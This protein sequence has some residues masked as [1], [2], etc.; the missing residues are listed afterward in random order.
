MS[1]HKYFVQVTDKSSQVLVQEI[2]PKLFSFLKLLPPM[3][4]ALNEPNLLKLERYPSLGLV[5]TTSEIE[6]FYSGV[7]RMS[8]NSLVKMVHYFLVLR[9]TKLQNHKKKPYFIS[10]YEAVLTSKASNDDSRNKR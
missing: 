7:A 3:D 5:Q 4:V 1:P 6:S 2:E 9:L 10:D 8:D